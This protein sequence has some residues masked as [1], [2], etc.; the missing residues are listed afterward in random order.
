MGLIY[1]M[2]VSGVNAIHR[3]DRP[4]HCAA[5]GNYS[6]TTD[7]GKDMRIC[8][9]AGAPRRR[10]TQLV[11]GV[12]L[13]FAPA[14]LAAQAS[15]ATIGVTAPCYVNA[16]PFKGATITILGAGFPGG[17]QVAVEGNGVY[18]LAA[19]DPTTGTF[20]V[21][22]AGPTLA[23]S[24]P[25][26]HTY[27][28]LATDQTTGGV[29]AGT[30]VTMANLS[31]ATVPSEAKFTRRV[32]WS[33]SGFRPGKYVYA[34]YLRK[35]EVA[36]ARFGRANGPCGVLKVKARLYP[37]GHPRYKTYKVQIDDSKR[38]SQHA[39]PRIDTK[40]TSFAF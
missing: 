31:V 25:G 11:L 40:L 1:Q 9:R 7:R 26:T 22:T 33:F 39:A 35:R 23:T 28:L 14:A 27:S 38:Y 24:G 13:L 34:H 15:A 8:D 4:L 30:T 17:D 18:A 37:G 10:A 5:A 2:Q 21:T 19:A 6:Q 32:T 29:N 36:R 3:R 12:A 20:A 16:N